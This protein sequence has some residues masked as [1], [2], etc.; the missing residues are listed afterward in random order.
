[1]E[2]HSLAMMQKEIGSYKNIGVQVGDKVDTSG[3]LVATCAAS[4]DMEQ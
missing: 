4:A 2:L 1:M 3:S